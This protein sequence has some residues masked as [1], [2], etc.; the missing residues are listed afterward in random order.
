MATLNI[1]CILDHCPMCKSNSPSLT[2]KRISINCVG[3][4]TVFHKKCAR[5]LKKLDNGAFAVCCDDSVDRS[6]LSPPPDEY[7]EDDDLDLDI[8]PDSFQ[9]SKSQLDKIIQKAAKKAALETINSFSASIDMVNKRILNLDSKA[10]QIEKTYKELV[11][12]IQEAESCIKNSFE[13]NCDVM[14]AEFSDRDF[15]KNN[16]ILHGLL[17]SRNL[18]LKKQVSDILKNIVS[19]DLLSIKPSRIGPFKPTVKRPV[20]IKLPDRDNVF[21]ILNNNEK[22]PEGISFSCD[23]TLMQRNI[24]KKYSE[25]IKEHNTK[26]PNDLLSIKHLNNI[27]T[28]INSENKVIYPDSR[29]APVS[30]PKKA[31]NSST[32]KNSTQDT[33]VKKK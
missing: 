18:E 33:K 14:Y 32:P 7:D 5:N 6:I 20:R 9:I 13:N 30:H 31:N 23:R 21:E 27:P 15:R 1:S 29:Y 2:D 10:T 28:V 17:E 11:K 22:W 3:C 4:D 16:I 8:L 24:L 12:K 25:L 19:F 26:N